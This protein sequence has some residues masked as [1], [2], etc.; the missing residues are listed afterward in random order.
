M[1]WRKPGRATSDDRLCVA[2]DCQSQV[3]RYL[4]APLCEEHGLKVWAAVNV[5]HDIQIVRKPKPRPTGVDGYVYIIR[6][7]D[8]VKI[9]YTTVPDSRLKHLPHDEVLAVFPG[10]MAVERSLHKRFAPFL[11][12]QKE[13]FHADESIIRLAKERDRRHVQHFA[14]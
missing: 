12:A 1:L 13:W 2:G 9:G 10:S 8:K 5:H 11:C 6:F 3:A 4:I 14:S 7:G